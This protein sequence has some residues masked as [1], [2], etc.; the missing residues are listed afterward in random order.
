MRTHMGDLL[1]DQYVAAKEKEDNLLE[2]EIKKAD[3]RYYKEI[4]TKRLKKIQT[5]KDL[6]EFA[7]KN[8][9]SS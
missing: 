5:K 9:P 1:N 3:D 8:V 7:R 2:K 6:M 4:E